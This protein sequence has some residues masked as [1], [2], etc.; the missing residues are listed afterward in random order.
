MVE[1][2]RETGRDR[3]RL[4]TLRKVPQDAVQIVR[5]PVSSDA[6]DA[7]D[8]LDINPYVDQGREIED[9]IDVRWCRDRRTRKKAS[10]VSEVSEAPETGEQLAPRAEALE[11]PRAP[12]DGERE[13]AWTAVQAEAFAAYRRRRRVERMASRDRIAA[14][15]TPENGLASDGA[16]KNGTQRQM[17][18]LR[19]VISQAQRSDR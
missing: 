4:I 18:V 19:I 15:T 8:G 16:S 1:H 9:S 11:E 10:E 7:S 17:D 6:S 2:G 12:A 3:T 13:E 5:G 14:V